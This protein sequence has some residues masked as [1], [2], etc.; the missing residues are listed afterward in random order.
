[1]KSPIDIF[2][3]EQGFMLL[4]G[5][6]ATELERRG[7]DL[8]H[9][10]WSARLLISDPQA[11][12]AVHRAYLEVGADCIISASYQASLNGFLAEGY[13]KSLALKLIKKSAEIACVVRDKFWNKAEN[14]LP[15]RLP[16]LVAASI[17]PYGAARADGSEYR[18]DYRITVQKLKDFHE[19]RWEILA[20]SPADCLACETIPDIHEAQALHC[21]IKQVPDRCVWVSFSCADGVRISDGTRLREAVSLFNDCPNVL[22][23]GVNCTP[24]RFISSLIEEIKNGISGKQIIVYPNSGEVY[25]AAGKTWQGAADPFNFASAAGEWFKS[26][27]KLIGGCCRTGPQHIQ[28]VRDRLLKVKIDPDEE[29]SAHI[30]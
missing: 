3:K 28:L 14:R 30:G 15:E 19:P 13:K 20:N 5:G 10:L 11:I 12:A 9:P 7:H 4:D 16:P 26:G 23:C 29:R 27:A 17:G 22:A 1:M 24:P 2:L 25:N 6:L 8:N 21:L 18:G